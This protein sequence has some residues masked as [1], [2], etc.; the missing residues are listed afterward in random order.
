MR[1]EFEGQK[2]ILEFQRDFK[3]T[4]VNGEIKKASK[5]YTTV[6]LVRFED[7]KPV[8]HRTATVGCWHRDVYTLEKGRLGALRLMT[9]GNGLSKEF[10]RV[11]WKAY[12]ERG[13]E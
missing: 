12:M 5:P 8:V 11:L 2:Y 1:F 10:K 7:D 9:K 3:E 4:T 13:K 6:N